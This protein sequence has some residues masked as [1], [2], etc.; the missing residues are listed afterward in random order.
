MK[1]TEILPS[2]GSGRRTMHEVLCAREEEIGEWMELALRVKE[3]FPGFEEESYRETV[4]RNMARGSALCVR[5]DGKLAGILLYS[6]KHGCLSC[7]AAA[8]EY[9]RR[10]VGRALVQRMLEEMD[11]DVWVDTFR[12]GDPMGIAP[13]ALYRQCGFTEGE[14]MEDFGYPVQRM[15]RKRGGMM[16]E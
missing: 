13:R 7:M 9:R 4:L 11:G 10:G 14:L 8:P 5:I 1:N 12:E 6:K 15:H 3:N 16:N 2:S